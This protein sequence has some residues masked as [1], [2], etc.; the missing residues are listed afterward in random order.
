[1]PVLTLPSQRLPDAASLA[2]RQA[3]AAGF[4]VHVMCRPDDLMGAIQ[5]YE[6]VS[7]AYL[8]DS[9]LAGSRTTL[10]VDH[11]MVRWLLD[12][13][14]DR[15]TLAKVIEEAAVDGQ[16]I[17]SMCGW[18]LACAAD[19]ATRK[20]ASLAGA[21]RMASEAH[22][23]WKRRGATR[24]TLRRLWERFRPVA[25]LWAA[26]R[27]M[28]MSGHSDWPV[29][30][31]RMD[32]FFL[33]AEKIRQEGEAHVSRHARE[34]LLDTTASVTIPAHRLVMMRGDWHQPKLWDLRNRQPPPRPQ[35]V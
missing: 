14:A 31:E 11:D 27:L 19:S 7:G 1:M 20:E 22:R 21:I 26:D 3:I 24:S 34:P 15:H 33:L 30:G 8:L 12:A 17:G 16:I 9:D 28:Q 4:V 10:E 32:A 23:A 25:H 18:I 13:G 6:R 29:R 5:T 35:P 2:D